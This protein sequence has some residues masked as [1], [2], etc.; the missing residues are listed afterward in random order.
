[1]YLGVDFP[2]S[3]VDF[4]PRADFM[5]HL[6]NT[7]LTRH[8]ADFMKHIFNTRL[9]HAAVDRGTLT[10]AEVFKAFSFALPRR[11]NLSTD[12]CLGLSPATTTDN[13]RWSPC[14]APHICSRPP[15][16]APGSSSQSLGEKAIYRNES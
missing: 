12:I 10:S 3:S 4:L 14:P 8:A 16:S 11:L 13:P 2:D 6:F 9:T 5:K 7:R 15:R 1:M